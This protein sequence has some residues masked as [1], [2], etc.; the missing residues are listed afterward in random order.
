MSRDW[1]PQFFLLPA[2]EDEDELHKNELHSRR[3][4]WHC[5]RLRGS[6]AAVRLG[7][8][9]SVPASR[10]RQHRRSTSDSLQR[11]WSARPRLRLLH[12]HGQREPYAVLLRDAGRL[13]IADSAHQA[14]GDSEHRGEEPKPTGTC[15]FADRGRVERV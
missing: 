11:E 9:Q 2:I 13:R 3:Y 5:C 4:V 6:H 1:S 12:N 7:R 8:R 14:G 15:R 10:R